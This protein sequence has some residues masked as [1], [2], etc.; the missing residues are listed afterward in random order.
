[1]TLTSLQYLWWP[2]IFP[3]PRPLGVIHSFSYSGERKEE[4]G[5]EKGEERR[6]EVGGTRVSLV[7]RCCVRSSSKLIGG[8]ILLFS[9]GFVGNRC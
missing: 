9:F 5:E 7:D 8:K 3:L 2:F 1:L 4:R 6:E